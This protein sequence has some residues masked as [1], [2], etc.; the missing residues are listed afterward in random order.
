M[1]KC[2]AVLRTKIRYDVQGNEPQLILLTVS[3]QSYETSLY[4]FIHGKWAYFA[5]SLPQS[6]ALDKFSQYIS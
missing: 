5:Q 6:A 1:G 4:K 3:V 2:Q